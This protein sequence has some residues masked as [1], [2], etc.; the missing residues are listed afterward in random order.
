MGHVSFVLCI[1]YTCNKKGIFVYKEYWGGRSFCVVNMFIGLY[2]C[3]CSET[4]AV[5]TCEGL[6]HPISKSGKMSN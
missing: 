5:T 1:V 3:H 6:N 2:I 4:H